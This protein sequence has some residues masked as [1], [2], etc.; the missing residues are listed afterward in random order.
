MS[1]NGWKP[2]PALLMTHKWSSRCLNPSF[3]RFGVPRIVISDGGS[4]FINRIF[5]NL[6]KKHGVL[7]KLPLLTTLKLVDKLRSQ[8]ENSRAYFRRQQEDKKDWSAKLDDAL[9]AYRT[10]FKTPLGTPPFIF[11]W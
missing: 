8:T 5:A 6:L 11:L 4:H 9:W 10:A 3:P 2:L 7:T 1:P